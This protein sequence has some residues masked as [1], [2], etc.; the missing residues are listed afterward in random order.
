MSQEFDAFQT[1]ATN[2]V[3]LLRGACQHRKHTRRFTCQSI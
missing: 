1:F 3:R 2:L